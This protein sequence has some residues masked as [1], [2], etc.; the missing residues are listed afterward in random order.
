MSW[1]TDEILFY[2]GIVAIASA[3]ALTILHFPI[4]QIRKVKL[5]VKLDAEYGEK[6]NNRR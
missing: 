2:G 4:S 6:E 1:L 3:V 5:N